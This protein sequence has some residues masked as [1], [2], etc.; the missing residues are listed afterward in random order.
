MEFTKELK[1]EIIEKIIKRLKINKA[2]FICNEY[3]SITQC[4]SDDMKSEFPELYDMIMKKGK[5]IYKNES[6]IFPFMWGDAFW[7][8]N[9]YKK[10]IVI[11]EKFL[12]KITNG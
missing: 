3:D 8:M 1:I 5:K 6:D 11:L 4:K 2:G 9:E 7:Y 10:R 12:K